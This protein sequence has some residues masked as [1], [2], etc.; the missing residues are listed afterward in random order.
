MGTRLRR[1]DNWLSKTT[2]R[3]GIYEKKIFM[4]GIMRIDADN[5]G[6]MWDK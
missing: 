4:R 2:G 3:D 6:G 5:T 1:K